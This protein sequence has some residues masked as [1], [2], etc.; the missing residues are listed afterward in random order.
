MAK[1]HGIAYDNCKDCESRCAHAGENRSFVCPKGVSCKVKKET[2]ETNADRIR[3]MS[4]EELAQ[5]PKMFSGYPCVYLDRE[6]GREEKCEDC[7]LEWLRQP[8]EGWHD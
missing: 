6:C 3:A 7:L 4:D 5:V 8:V 2:P 1:S